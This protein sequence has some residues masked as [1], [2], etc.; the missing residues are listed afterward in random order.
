MIATTEGLTLVRTETKSGKA[1]VSPATGGS[2]QSGLGGTV[3]SGDG[4]VAGGGGVSIKTQPAPRLRD[5]IM[6]RQ[7]NRYFTLTRFIV[8]LILAYGPNRGKESLRRGI[9]HPT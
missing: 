4:A 8:D 6:I 9:G 7:I 1:E 3:I 5:R 2:V